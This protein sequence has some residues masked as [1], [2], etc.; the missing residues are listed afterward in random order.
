MFSTRAPLVSA[1][2]ARPHQRRAA[3]RSALALVVVVAAAAAN[4]NGSS[5]SGGSSG[6]DRNKSPAPP[7]PRIIDTS[8]MSLKQQKA[9]V[10]TLKKGTSGSSDDSDSDGG[11]SGG[12]SGSGRPQVARKFRRPKAT[13]EQREAQRLRD[14]EQERRARATK[15]TSFALR[16]IYGTKAASAN[17]PVLLVDGYNVG[18]AWAKQRAEDL[19]PAERARRDT[20]V[21][22]L[23]GVR[24]AL[25]LDLCEFS[26]VA[27][28][29]VV[30][31]FDAMMNRHT[32]GLQAAEVAG[33][34]VVFCGDRDAD[35]FLMAEARRLTSGKGGGGGGSGEGGGGTSGAR[36]ED[37]APRQQQ[38]PCR[39]VVASSDREVQMF[40]GSCGFI[41]SELLLKE[42]RRAA[43]AADA[44]YSLKAAA[45]VRAGRGFRARLR[46]EAAG[47]LRAL[48]SRLLEE[49][50]EEL[51]LLREQ[52]QREREEREQQKR[53]EAAARG[54]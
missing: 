9:L 14:E 47:G 23:D 20:A 41:S 44:A 22:S 10:A 29:K 40:S 25:L 35:A 33:V 37:D 16:N 2:R 11:S 32:R 42:M 1:V 3:P 45:D 52:R 24:Q 13:P 50:K 19:T 38:Q 49:S 54:T 27:K 43:R 36:R 31:A 30:V 6:D 5:S 39:V 53:E 46:P 17:P 21:Q 28:V 7:P 34:K 8:R 51:R 12:K 26:Q 4:K 18:F 48:R 15:G